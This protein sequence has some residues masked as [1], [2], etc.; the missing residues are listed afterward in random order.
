MMHGHGKS[1]RPIVPAKP[2]NEVEPEAKRRWREGAGQ[3]EC[4]QA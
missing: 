3:G 4:A 1:D 2:P